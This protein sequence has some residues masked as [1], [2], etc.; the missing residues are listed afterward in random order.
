MKF[1]AIFGLTPLIASTAL[2]CNGYTGGVPVA[3]NTVSKS[4]Y[5]EVKA[6]EVYDGQWQRFDRGSGACGGDN[7]GGML[8]Q[9]TGKAPTIH[10]TED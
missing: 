8:K 10:K 6:G 9:P 1:S 3:T 7:E 2:A 4:T 5:I